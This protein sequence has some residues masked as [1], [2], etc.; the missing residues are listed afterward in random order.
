MDIAPNTLDKKHQNNSG[1]ISDASPPRRPRPSPLRPV[2]EHVLSGN[3]S[4]ASP[5]RRPIASGLRHTP[6]DRRP[7]ITEK[8]N[9]KVTAELE[10]NSGSSRGN[11]SHGLEQERDPSLTISER[12]PSVERRFD[13][14]DD[15]GQS[16]WARSPAM[17]SFGDRAAAST[18]WTNSQ[19]RPDV[20]V[21]D[22][23]SKQ[24][25][26]KTRISYNRYTIPAGPR[27]DGVDRSNGFEMRI[28]K[29]RAQMREDEQA[30][31]KA[32]VS[33]M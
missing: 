1:D 15:V 4:D 10:R 5:P 27:W 14:S 2:P 20:N 11:L 22:R 8:G 12:K 25:Q 9:K 18:G 17:T 3:V 7:S 33:D 23:S 24:T 6:R 32:S 30:A 21:R 29:M 28:A 13:S 26:T 19:P 31:Y 16:L